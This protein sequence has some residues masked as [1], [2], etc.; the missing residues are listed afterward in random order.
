MTFLNEIL[1]RIEFEQLLEEGRDPREVLHYKYQNVPSDVIDAVIEIDPTKKKSYS[2]WLLSKWDNESDEITRNLNNGRIQKMFQHYKEHP[3]V[4]IQHCPSVEAG[5]RFVP[6]EDTVLTKSDESTTTL[7]NNGWVEEVPSE[8]ANDFDIVFDED[9]WIIA[10]PNTYEADCKLGEN[11]YWCTAGG[12]TDFRGGRQYY[13]HYLENGDDKYYVNFDMS[14]GESRLG[15]DYPFTR[16]QF[17]FP[18]HQF[19]DKDDEPVTLTEIDMP[20]SAFE[21][22]RSEGIDDSDFEDME[23]KIEHYEQR[24]WEHGYSI[25]DDLYLLQEYDDNYE[26]TEPDENTSFYLYD[27]DRDDRDPIGWEGVPNPNTN[28]VIISNNEDVPY[29]ILRGESSTLLAINEQNPSSS[30]ANSRWEMYQIAE[31]LELPS[32]LGVFAVSNDSSHFFTFYSPYGENE[33]K[34]LDATNVESMVINKVCTQADEG[35]WYRIFIET[36]CDDYHSLFTVGGDSNNG[37]D[38]DCIVHRDTPRNGEYYIIS[39]NGIVEGMFG[40]YRAYDDGNPSEDGQEYP[41]YHLEREIANGCYVVTVNEKE[42]D[43]YGDTSTK[44]LKN[45]VT[46]WGGDL[47]LKEWVDDFI[48]ANQLIIVAEKQDKFGYFDYNGQQIGEWYDKWGY[49]DIKKGI[50]CG[51][52]QGK[53]VHFIDLQQKDVYA[54]FQGLGSNSPVN[55]KVVVGVYNPRIAMNT[56]VI[57]DYVQR[58]LCNEE[59]ESTVKLYSANSRYLYCYLRNSEEKAI[60]DFKKQEYVARGISDVTRPDSHSD[61]RVLQKMDGKFNV[62]GFRDKSYAA[63]NIDAEE[64]LPNNVDS[65]VE[66][67]EWTYMIIY[68]IN[69][70]YFAYDYKT[71]LSL[72]NPNG[73]DYPLQ[74]NYDNGCIDCFN[75]SGIGLEF[76]KNFDNNGTVL[77]RWVIQNGSEY[78]GG[79][80]EIDH[81]TPQEVINFYNQVVG[82]PQVQTQQQQAPQGENELA[83]SVAEE[84]KK[85]MNRINEARKLSYR[86]FI[87]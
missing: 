7:M 60:F 49:L 34:H 58:R 24:R 44:T 85:L 87:D 56:W 14:K 5:L 3:E 36:I 76:R 75:G 10:V 16:Y 63:T 55:N 35:K 45:I 62:F 12:R 51:V 28:D 17:H 81:N 38:L 73:V 6:E 26:Y 53:N 9:D 72:V 8:L 68:T 40:K 59:I 32:G 20:D 80:S 86:E 67:E 23:A 66:A 79:G 42:T 25:T 27:V 83:Y 37:Y 22:Y 57:Y 74:L 48:D 70:K 39:E 21:F 52:N 50:A 11:M 64:L 84:F 69:G 15:K 30:W 43:S 71:N 4:Q 78:G 31:F 61:L 46:Q 47:L 41:N 65:I 33:Y 54:E 82:Q 19:M 13:D 1:D 77:K 29:V 2:Q 18:S